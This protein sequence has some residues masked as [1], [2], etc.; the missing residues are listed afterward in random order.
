MDP[1]FC[2]N[3]VYHFNRP[4]RRRAYID[5]FSGPGKCVVDGTNEYFLG[6]PLLSVTTE[7]PFTDY[8]F[9]DKDSKNIDVLE[10]RISEAGLVKER[11]KCLTG[12]ANIKVVEVVREIQRID[13]EF[14]SGVWP[15]LNLA[16]LDPEGLELEWNTVAELGKINRMDLIIHYSQQGIKRMADRAVE[17]NKETVVD[18]FFGD[19]EW[20]KIYLAYKN[21]AVGIHRHLMDYYKS[22]LKTLGY[23]EVKDDEE[24]WA[25]PLMKNSKNAPL[26]RLLFASKHPLGV[27]FWKDVTKVG[28][29]GQFP[30]WNS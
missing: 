6:S 16:F 21:D 27:K 3:L 8:Y 17:S 9:V 2:L 7:H 19:T 29:D 10:K 14:I 15:S 13:S 1:F 11:V 18:K 5:L 23:V 28:R 12:D 20:R 4:W 25:E 30:L 22:K 26:Y 24:I